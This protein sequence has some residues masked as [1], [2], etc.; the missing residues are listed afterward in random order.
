MVLHIVISLR[1]RSDRYVFEWI[2]LREKNGVA[3][4]QPIIKTQ[5]LLIFF[6]QSFTQIKRLKSNLW[7]DLE[8]EVGNK[9]GDQTYGVIYNP[10]YYQRK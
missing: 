7:C 8:L 4:S 9:A 5:Y 3:A 10:F 1:P 6:L 2:I